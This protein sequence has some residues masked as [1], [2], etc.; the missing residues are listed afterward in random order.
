MHFPPKS[1]TSLKKIPQHY[2]LRAFVKVHCLSCYEYEVCY[3][4]IF[5]LW[6]NSLLLLLLQVSVVWFL[7]KLLCYSPM[8][9]YI[10]SI[11][12]LDVVE[13]HQI[14]LLS[15]LNQSKKGPFLPCNHLILL[16]VF[17]N[18]SFTFPNHILSYVRYWT[19]TSGTCFSGVSV[20][21]YALLSHD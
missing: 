9:F 11:P 13:Q 10:S 19:K 2:F 7:T 16:K 15:P 5:F 12:S 21:F 4:L 6:V 20:A 17:L 18:C 14:Y 1:I 8:S 3:R